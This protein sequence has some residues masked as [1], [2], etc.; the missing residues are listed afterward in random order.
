MDI[1]AAGNWQGR[2]GFLGP[3][4][5][6]SGMGMSLRQLERHHRLTA[7]EVRFFKSNIPL[8]QA[9]VGSRHPEPQKRAYSPQLAAG[10]ASA[11]KKVSVPYG[12]RSPVACYGEL[13]F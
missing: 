4:L 8:L 11:S 7:L 2:E 5:L 12:R 9:T 13:Q 10:L 3:F 6:L 1:T